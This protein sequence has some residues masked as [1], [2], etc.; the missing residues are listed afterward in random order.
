MTANAFDNNGKRGSGQA[1]PHVSTRSQ[2]VATPGQR[3]S[4]AVGNVAESHRAP[5][6]H[7]ST[8]PLLSPLPVDPRA[9]VDG[10]PI[11]VGSI[12]W[13]INAGRVHRT[14]IAKVHLGM[15]WSWFGRQI[16]ATEP[17]ALRA[18]IDLEH[19]AAARAYAERRRALGAVKRFAARL[20]ALL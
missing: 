1:A 19:D 13:R 10:T 8:G 15:W 17:A 7:R 11:A 18:A 2:G 3:E 4:A 14:T 6:G 16:Y 20:G 9:T 12:V 5:I